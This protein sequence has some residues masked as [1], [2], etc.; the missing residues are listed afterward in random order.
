MTLNFCKKHPKLCACVCLSV[1][2]SLSAV[3]I[4]FR[5]IGSLS[6]ACFPATRCVLPFFF[7][8]SC[9]LPF[10][11]A[12]QRILGRHLTFRVLLCEMSFFFLITFCQHVWSILLL[13]FLLAVDFVLSL[14]VG[15]VGTEKH[16]VGCSG[17]G[18]TILSPLPSLRLRNDLSS[19]K[20]QKRDRLVGTSLER[21]V[22]Q[23]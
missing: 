14:T 12:K 18:C 15:E 4:Q 10:S 20:A 23:T 22:A 1:S 11:S 19:S 2:L 8:A 17:R 13:L 7:V 6:P 16:D 5:S 9:A 3:S 21:T